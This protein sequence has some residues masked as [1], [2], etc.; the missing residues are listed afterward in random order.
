[1]FLD[2]M[3]AFNKVLKVTLSGLKP[4]D[5]SNSYLQTILQYCITH[6]GAHAHQCSSPIYSSTHGLVLG[7]P[8]HCP[9][10]SRSLGLQCMLVGSIFDSLSSVH[11][12]TAATTAAAAATG[13]NS[14]LCM[15]SAPCHGKCQHLYVHLT[16]A[17]VM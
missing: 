7:R 13:N 16:P 12:A 11:E 6:D 9:L 14:F 15:L 17:D 2:L 4:A 3:Q 5:S 1:M 8:L 10:C